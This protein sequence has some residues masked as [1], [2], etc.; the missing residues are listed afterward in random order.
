MFVPLTVTP[1]TVVG[2]AAVT[3]ISGLGLT[4]VGE[5]L[6][7]PF[8]GLAPSEAGSVVIIVSSLSN[9]LSMEQT[10]VGVVPAA[11]A[12]V[13]PAAPAVGDPAAPA[14]VDPA[15]P[16]VV[17]PA[18]PAVGDPAAPAVVDPA[19][20]AVVDPAAPAVVDPAAPA[21]VDPAA[22]AV[23]DPAS[24]LGVVPAGRLVVV[25]TSPH[26]CIEKSV[27]SIGC[28]PSTGVKMTK[29]VA[30]PSGLVAGSSNVPWSYL[31]IKLRMFMEFSP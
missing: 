11:P 17:D 12:V 10:L 20:P 14:V 15:A 24:S 16:A 26:T 28:D 19:T 31:L 7:G 21:V 22:P 8:P 13:D 2:E 4:S 25:E 29:I 9:K 1:M 5:I 3:V 27:T 30:T 23:V 6:K 18:A